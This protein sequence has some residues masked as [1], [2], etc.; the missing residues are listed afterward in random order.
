MKCLSLWQPWAQAVALGLKGY[1]TRHWTTNYRGPLAIHAAKRVFNVKIHDPW[2]LEACNQL[3]KA[4]CPHYV[5]DYGK[6]LCVA[7]LTDCVPTGR[8]RDRIAAR[9]LFWGD[10]RNQG[11]DGKPRFAWALKNVRPIPGYLRP[12]VTG[13]QGLFDIPD[14]IVRFE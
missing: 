4:G 7:D 11:D 5:V 8:V 2:I 9:E 10:F 3:S 1:E 6:V 12:E 13:R 14:D